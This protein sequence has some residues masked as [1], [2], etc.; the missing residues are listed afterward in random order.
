MLMAET[1]GIENPPVIDINKLIRLIVDV[2]TGDKTPA[3]AAKEF[4]DPYLSF[5]KVFASEAAHELIKDA[6]N[7]LGMESLSNREFSDQLIGTSG[8]IVDC[9]RAFIE[10]KISAQ[11]L[12]KSIGGSGIKEV[13]MQVLAALGVHKRL[14]LEHPEEILK[15]APNVMAYNASIAAYE[16]LRKAMDDL[17]VA[18]E[19]RKQIEEACR[20]A[21]SMI[22]HYRMEMERIVS[23]YL[24]VRLK[25][26]ESGFAAMDKALS[27]G[28]IDGYIRGN[29]EIQKILGRKIQFVDQNEFDKLMDS[30]EA[31]RL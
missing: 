16:E 11:E 30:D 26:F 18:K 9:V 29:V 25:T 23:Q 24:S 2:S 1:K 7:K 20:E 21:V 4:A 28:D 12:V 8:R 22:R 6:V 17:A 31:F 19:R 5:V 14:G 3:E 13:S 10:R 27:D 15:L